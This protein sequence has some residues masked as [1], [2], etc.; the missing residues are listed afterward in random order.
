MTYEQGNDT[1]SS[2]P[3]LTRIL[4]ISFETLLNDL[5]KFQTMEVAENI[6]TSRMESSIAYHI[7]VSTLYFTFMHFRKHFTLKNV[8]G[9]SLPIIL[10]R[11]KEKVCICR[12]CRLDLTKINQE[13]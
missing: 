2:N 3:Y 1:L 5:L 6:A 11:A 8:G 13:T 12:R 9:R 10:H 7:F 4:F